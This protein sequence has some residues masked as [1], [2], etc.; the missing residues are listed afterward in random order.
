[1]RKFGISRRPLCLTVLIISFVLLLHRH[2]YYSFEFKPQIKIPQELALQ[3]RA[4]S[5]SPFALFSGQDR[6]QLAESGPL[7]GFRSWPLLEKCRWFF[8]TTYAQDSS[9]TNN[10]ILERFEDSRADNSRLSHVF[11][12]LRMFD[13]CF[14]EGQLTMAQVLPS[15]E[16]PLDFHHRMFPFLASF[17][18]LKDIWPTIFHLNTWKSLPA[19]I[20]PAWN[21]NTRVPF[22]IDS[23]RSFWENWA[24]FSSGKGLVMSL[25][26]RHKDLFF[27]LLRVLD[28]LDNK[29][30]IQLV[31]QSGELSPEFLKA[32]GRFLQTTNQQVYLIECGSTLNQ[33]YAPHMTYFV[34][35]WIATIFNTFSEF[36]L[37][38]AD[39]VPF[40]DLE[41]F[42]ANPQYQTTGSLLY[43]DRDISDEFTFDYCIEMFRYLEPSTEAVLFMDHRTKINAS[44]VSPSTSKFASE[45]ELVYSRFF[46]NKILHNVDSGLVVLHKVQQLPSLLMSFFM[47]LDS[48]A[49]GC[50]YGD[51]ELFWIGHLFSGKDFSIDARFGAVVGPIQT[52]DKSPIGAEYK[53]CA[54]QMGHV[55]AEKE[56]LWANG[57]LKTCKIPTAADQDFES[58]PN[59]FETHYSSL[60]QLEDL[61]DTPLV[62][63]G[64][65]IP[66]IVTNPWLKVNECCE[67]AY[68]ATAKIPMDQGTQNIENMAV[69]NKTTTGRYN[70]IAAIWNRE[71]ES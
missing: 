63:N 24:A 57:G 28:H 68:C 40:V 16:E 45:E 15:G 19:Q 41:T 64:Y 43:K 62:I 13:T 10:Q 39:V 50:V 22:D 52:Q 7:Q 42:F 37:L 21:S 61:Y 6:H 56:L 53:V 33:A 4:L 2:H 54:T 12:R 58:K 35:K 71:I 69:F 48:K 31:Q 51:K 59:Y 46:Y 8:Y 9:W 70:E 49:S 5:N 55:N 29:F 25:A 36:I 18:T 67:Y 30:P 32:V 47:N 44:V 17:S 14:V 34:N 65:I 11:E 3:R 26:E 60:Q 20:N 1:M 23:S 38:D 66:E 27:R